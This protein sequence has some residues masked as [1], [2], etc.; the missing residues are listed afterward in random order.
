VV[1]A[2]EL[3]FGVE[4][5]EVGVNTQPHIAVLTFKSYCVEHTQ[6]HIQLAF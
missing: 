2:S 4:H 3:V 1:L 6:H 5:S